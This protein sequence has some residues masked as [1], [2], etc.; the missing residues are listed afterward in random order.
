MRVTNLI[1][2]SQTCTKFNK[3]TF[4]CVMTFNISL[5]LPILMVSTRGVSGVLIPVSVR[6]SECTRHALTFHQLFTYS[7][8]TERGLE[9]N[10]I[11][12]RRAQSCRA[13][14]SFRDKWLMRSLQ[15]LPVTWKGLS[16]QITFGIYQFFFLLKQDYQQSTS[17]SCLNAF[18]KQRLS[19][20]TNQNTIR[21]DSCHVS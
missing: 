14:H 7:K 21:G 4:K 8:N 5:Q 13:T 2:I 12:T 10:A 16:I 6:H 11:Q 19:R 15:C 1:Y 3:S 17:S 18:V 9:G 20:I